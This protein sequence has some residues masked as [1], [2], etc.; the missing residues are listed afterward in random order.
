M[1]Y[2]QNDCN[3]DTKLQSFFYPLRSNGISSR[4]LFAC[5]S[6]KRARKSLFFAYHH[7]LACKKTPQWWYTT[8]RVGDM[9]FLTK[10]MIYKAYA[11]ILLCVCGIIN[12]PK[13]QNL[14]R[15]TYMK[16]K[17]TLIVA[18]DCNRALK[19]YSDMFCDIFVWYFLKNLGS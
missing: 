15:R 17:G 6:S 8:L 13:I 7:A 1:D 3:F 5:I 9:Q 2:S 4:N 14:T 18:K 10:L 12:S 11:L 16:Y 19:F